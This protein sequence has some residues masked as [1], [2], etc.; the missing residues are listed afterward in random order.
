M[1]HRIV[2]LFAGLFAANFA[3]AQLQQADS[4][5]AAYNEKLPQEK[6]HI[7]FD[8]TAY[9]PGQTIWYKAYLQRGNEA[10]DLSKNLYLDWYDETGRI[11][12]RNIAPVIGSCASGSYTVSA[13]YPG[14]R[15]RVV[16]YTKWM[17][18]F[19]S[20]LLFRQTLPVWQTQLQPAAATT[21]SVASIQFFPE[22]GDL[23]AGLSSVIACKAVNAS[24][25]P[26]TVQGVVLTHNKEV[27]ASFATEHDGMGRFSLTPV[28][29]EN[30]VAEWRD[31]QGNLRSTPLPN[32]TATGIVLRVNQVALLRSFTI[33]RQSDAEERFKKLTVV[34]TMNQQVLFRAVANL[35]AKN[36]LTASLPTSSF[37]SGIL[38]LTVFDAHLQPVA[39][40]IFFVNNGEYQ[41][42]A[43]VATDTFSLD[44]RGRNVYHIAVADTLPASL[45]LSIVDGGGV[46]DSSRTIISDLLL[47]SD[48]RGY[49][50]NPAYYFSSDEDSVQQH[51]D[52]VMLTHG[53]RRFRWEDVMTANI[54][55]VTYEKDTGYLS[56]TGK[57]DRLSESKIKKAETLN[58]VLMA[59]D[60]TKQFVFTPLHP[61]G[62]F[63]EDNL[64]LF[65][66]TKIFYQLN[67]VFL[68]SGSQVKINNTFLPFDSA[69]RITALAS[70]LPDTSGLARIKAIEAEQR[71]LTELLRQSTLKEVVVKTKTKTRLQEMNERY[72]SGLFGT[73]ESRDFLVADDPSGVSY[74]SVFSYLQGRVAGLQISNP[75]SP[76]PAVTW[77]RSNVSLF[78]DEMP[79]DAS[80]LASISMSGVAYVK[81]FPP[82]FFGAAGGGPGGAIAVY[83]RKGNDTKTQFTGLDYTSLPGYTPVKEFYSPDYSVPQV[84]F[85]QADLRRTLLWKPNLSYSGD[86]RTIEVAFY[87]N[88]ISHTLQLVLEGMTQEG[89]LI[90]VS[91]TLQ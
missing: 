26:V 5:L 1:K 68:P 67:R 33:Q 76:N 56:I 48:I 36:N 73:G 37:A 8:N 3:S 51:L 43:A 50:H 49:V 79:V 45:S 62:S 29:G 7:H 27:V 35:T 87:N 83:M 44:R 17:L 66:T 54:P 80:A 28:A 12:G 46:Q 55:A 71:K 70:Y 58:L 31:P 64:V 52:L 40:R 9:L 84:N 39:E 72:T 69:R 4:L 81:V 88:D 13:G 90:R 30:Y 25:F 41:V 63:R 82:P 91:K 65:D 75:Y 78:L 18:N 53:W 59:K 89:R 19:D 61:D 6:I 21:I 60:S 15:I 24:G 23:V 85:S 86:G 22:G 20:A 34:A 57:I 38:Q 42:A 14:S 11:L 2:L 10:S 47:T 74:P 77:R 16:A 32:V